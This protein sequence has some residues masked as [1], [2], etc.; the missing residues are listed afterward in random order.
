VFLAA[1]LLLLEE[2]ER[3]RSRLLWALPVLL[4]LWVN[5]HS[6]FVL[7]LVAIGIHW[8]ASS[9]M[10][11]QPDR[12]LLLAG[13]ASA[14][15][16]FLTP[17]FR[18]VA[19]FPLLQLGILREGL[20]K[21]ELVGTAEFLSPFRAAFYEIGSQ[22]VLWQPILFVHLYALMLVPAALAG[23]RR[24]RASDWALLGA[25]GYL[26][27]QAIKSFGYLVV[28][29]LPAAAEGLDALGERIR[30]A[31]RTASRPGLDRWL[32][33]ALPALVT[34]LALAVSVQ[35]LDG[36]WYA[37]QRSPHRLGG[38]FNERVLP[39]RAAAFLAG[40]VPGPRRLLNNWE[41]GG[42]LGFVTG[43]PVFIDGRNEI[44][45]EDFYREYLSAKVPETLP[46]VIRNHRIDGALVPFNDLPLWYHLFLQDG[47]W[48]LVHRD[49]RHAVFLREAEAAGLT[50]LGPPLP[51]ADYPLFDEAEIER[52]LERGLSLRR[53]SLL[54]S[55][56]NRHYDA[57]AQLD[58]SLLWLRSG[59]PEA[60]LGRGLEGLS[61]ATF[62]A[63]ELL[64]TLGHAFYDRGDRVRA[65]RCFDRALEKL[66]DPLARERLER[67]RRLGAVGGGEGSR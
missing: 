50:P 11:R 27:A 9:W 13:I 56:L 60:A 53:P 23:W 3:G 25:F 22:T 1:V 8:L 19:A 15:A 38:G 2:H 47:D 58:E 67:L 7:G 51:E 52:I 28:A 65:A 59:H 54:A 31:A 61:R 42:Y 62:P 57:Q 46:A 43:W 44:M 40:E 12:P 17:Y 48:D 63:P 6:L 35:V 20:V 14:L 36:Y 26:F 55:L 34:V 29:T 24:Y 37:S 39:V 4:A 49:D 30:L 41:A 18:T 33:R 64:A 10:F 32:R 21:S 66:D 5:L 16:C 45:G